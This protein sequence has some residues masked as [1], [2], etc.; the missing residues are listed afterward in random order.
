MPELGILQQ[1]Q[2]QGTIHIESVSQEVIH[3][4][5]M[6]TAI[7]EWQGEPYEGPYS[8]RP[9]VTS[10]SLLTRHKLMTDN[11]TVQEIP[12]Y[13]TTN[14]QGGYTVIIGGE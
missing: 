8:V 11:L 6:D 9:K 7:I 10:Q 4:M 2:Q 14:A 13:Q 12:Y 1:V 5:S 3:L